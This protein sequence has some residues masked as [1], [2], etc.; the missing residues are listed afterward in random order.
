M[1]KLKLTYFNSPGRAEG[2]RIALFMGGVEFEDERISKEEFVNR[3]QSLPYLAVPV[4]TL[5]DG[6]VIAQSKAILRYVGR[7]TKLYPEDIKQAMLVDEIID[8]LID[9]GLKM[10]PILF[11][12]D[13]ESKKKG[14]ETINNELLPFWAGSFEKRIEKYGSNGYSIGDSLT[15]ADIRLY[16]VF[17]GVWKGGVPHLEGISKD[18][19][20]KFPRL[21]EV[22]NKVGE[23]PKVLEWNKKNQK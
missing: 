21:I 2:I 19:L 3:K 8:G 14:I 9:M 20:N 4:L 6:E 5:E 10:M 11:D 7:L 23:H 12:Q 15:L 18:S 16:I 13:P 22:I 1:S 17:I